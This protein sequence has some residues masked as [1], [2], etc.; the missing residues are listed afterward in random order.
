MISVAQFYKNRVSGHTFFRGRTLNLTIAGL[1]NTDLHC[2]ITKVVV[3]KNISGFKMFVFIFLAF[4]TELRI[5]IICQ[6]NI[7]NVGDIQY[8]NIY[9]YT[10]F[11]KNYISEA[12]LISTC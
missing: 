4:V 1:N 5:K 11:I 8:K 10:E 2:L 3:K 9:R 6:I 12:S 7:N